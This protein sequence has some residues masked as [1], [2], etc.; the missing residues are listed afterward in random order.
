MR[1][2]STRALFSLLSVS[3]W[4]AGVALAADVDIGT[5]WIRGTVSG[6]QA[7]GAFMEI[8]SKNGA[9]LVGVACPVAGITEIHEMKMENGVM[10][11]R[12]IARL[13]LPAGK[14]VKLGP[15]GYHVMLMGL[16]QQLGKGGSVPLTLKVEHRDKTVETIT[17]KAEVRDLTSTAPTMPEHKH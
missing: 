5:P 17:V 14:P 11:M 8:T 6:Q 1:T 9:S 16:K 15:S 4:Y 7:T 12:A 10:K 13:D 3:A 2:G